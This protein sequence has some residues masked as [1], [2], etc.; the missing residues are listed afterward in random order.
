MKREMRKFYF[1]FAIAIVL[2]LASGVFAQSPVISVKAKDAVSKVLENQGISKKDIKSVEKVEFDKLPSQVDLRNID[3]TNLE[4]YEVDYGGD[5]PVFVVTASSQLLESQASDKI[6]KKM[7]LTYG[8]KG[9]TSES[10]FLKTGTGVDT[11]LE[12]GYVMM[13]DGSVTGISTNFEATRGEGEVEIVLYINGA[14]VGFR[15]TIG[16]TSLGAKKDYDTQ[17]IGVVKFDKGDVI[18]TYIIVNGDVSVKDIINL[19]EITTE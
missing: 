16:I 9:E 17:S 15:N 10:G 3:S 2:V 14:P 19:V 11:S 1:I 6:Y 7:L 4:V 18:S 13:R 8:F 12:K 5:V